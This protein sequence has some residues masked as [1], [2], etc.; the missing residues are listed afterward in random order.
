M[1]EET[2]LLKSIIRMREHLIR[3]GKSVKPAG[4]ILPHL[5]K[6]K[7]WLDFYPEASGDQVRGF[8]KRNEA[9]F[10]VLLPGKGSTSRES[11]EKKLTELF[12]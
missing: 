10:K 5:Q 3:T 12:G 6:V 2:K 7:G 11:I 1:S 9:S 4:K 8:Y